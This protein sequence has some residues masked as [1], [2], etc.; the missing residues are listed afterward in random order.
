MLPGRYGPLE[1]KIM[2]KTKQDPKAR[3][4][5]PRRLTYLA[6]SP[7]AKRTAKMLAARQGE[8]LSGYFRRLLQEDAQRAGAIDFSSAGLES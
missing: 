5:A 4:K 1:V 3:D 8:T 7:I 6:L 2:S